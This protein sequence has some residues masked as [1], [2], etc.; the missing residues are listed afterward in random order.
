MKDKKEWADKSKME[1]TSKAFNERN[2]K[3]WEKLKKTLGFSKDVEIE[4]KK[5]K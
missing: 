3:S 4:K 1:E 2:S 5:K